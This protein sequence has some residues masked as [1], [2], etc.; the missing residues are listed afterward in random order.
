MLNSDL[1]PHSLHPPADGVEPAQSKIP[2]AG[3]GE[4]QQARPILAT[5]V[6]LHVASTVRGLYDQLHG[7]EP[8]EQLLELRARKCASVPVSSQAAGPSHHRQAALRLM[9]GR[10]FCALAPI[11]QMLLKATLYGERTFQYLG[12]M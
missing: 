8:H 2:A 6:S 7:H 5:E 1:I 9:D 3:G 11:Y 4:V 10:P 12:M